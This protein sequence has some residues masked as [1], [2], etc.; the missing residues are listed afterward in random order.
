MNVL[1]IEDLYPNYE[2][3]FFK[4][5]DFRNYDAYAA[6]SGEKIGSLDNILVSEVGH[7]RYFVVDTGVWIFGKK[8]L[9]PVGLGSLDFNNERLQVSGIESK[10]QLER[11][12]S[13]SEDTVVNYEYEKQLRSSYSSLTPSYVAE[14]GNTYVHDDDDLYATSE[15]NLGSLKLYEERLVADK[16]RQKNGEV[17]IGKRVETQ[18]ET[19][20]VPVAKE[21]VV[22]QRKTP[23]NPEQAVDPSQASFNEGEVLRMEVYEETAE[24]NKQTFVREE[25][26]IRKE[27]EVETVTATEKL[28]REELE[29]STNGNPRLER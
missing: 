13:Y 23:N 1:P 14:G 21:R 9:L 4:G 16:Q 12:P 26:S 7:F 18:K 25:V 10:D 19:V 15:A 11:I 2:D 22:I 3:K 24:I 5:K 29:L 27:T 17:S 6:R 20:S 28:K 8:V